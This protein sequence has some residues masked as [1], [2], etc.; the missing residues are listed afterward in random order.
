MVQGSALREWSPSSALREW[1]P[2][3]ALRE[4]SPSSA[5]REWSPYYHMKT[6]MSFF[7]VYVLL[8]KDKKLYIGFTS[9][10][11][12]RI[13]L[14]QKGNVDSTRPRLPLKLIFYE[15]YKNKYDALR[16]EKYLKTSKGK[17]TLKAMLREYFSFK[18]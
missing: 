8:L 14:H 16:R 10:L 12:N 5:L 9:D 3:S 7:Y 15:A 4:W 2:S 11:K 17:N 1:S 6:K 13:E 18:N